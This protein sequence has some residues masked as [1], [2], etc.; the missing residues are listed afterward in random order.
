P[1]GSRRLPANQRK[2]ANQPEWVKR[3]RRA[4]QRRLL[5][6]RKPTKPPEQARRRQRRS[7]PKLRNQQKLARLGAQPKRRRPV[8]RL[9]RSTSMFQNS[10]TP[11]RLRRLRSSK[12]NIL[13]EAKIGKASNM[14]FSATTIQSGT[15]RVGGTVIM[16]VTSCSCLA[17][18]IF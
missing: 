18:R 6:L 1:R 9:R 13:K 10:Q 17:P 7:Q 12:A 4:S 5:N 3:K 11:L 8:R 16:A 15:M 14:L 2:L